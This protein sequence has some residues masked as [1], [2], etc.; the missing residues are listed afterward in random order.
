MDADTQA[1]NIFHKTSHVSK[2]IS[3]Q[4]TGTVICE[5]VRA[6]DNKSVTRLLDALPLKHL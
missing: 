3:L 6:K 5:A 4:Q 2:I 1:S